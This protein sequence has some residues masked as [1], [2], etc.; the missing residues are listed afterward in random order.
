MHVYVNENKN[1][2]FSNTHSVLSIVKNSP[3]EYR[4]YAFQPFELQRSVRLHPG[5]WRAWCPARGVTILIL[6]SKAELTDSL[7]YN[8]MLRHFQIYIFIILVQNILVFSCFLS[9]LCFS[10]FHKK[11][12]NVLNNDIILSK[13]RKKH[14]ISLY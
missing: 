6:Y 11:W 2:W 12:H 10:G 3:S 13:I 1:S 7:T 4:D 14:N 8:Q 5:G 9:A